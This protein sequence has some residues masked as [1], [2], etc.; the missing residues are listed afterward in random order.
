MP[1]PRPRDEIDA[2]YNSQRWRKVRQVIIARD[3]GLCQECKRRGTIKKG[4]VVHHIIEAREDVTKFWDKDNLELVCLACHNKE[5]PEKSGGSK[6]VK[7]KRKVVKFYA[8]R[9]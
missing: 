3:Y 5:H 4:V 6:K 7:T 2:L 8:T 9:E 1:E